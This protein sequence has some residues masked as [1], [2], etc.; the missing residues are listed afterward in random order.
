MNII[1]E[2]SW[3]IYAVA[4]VAGLAAV[5][6]MYRRRQRTMDNSGSNS[7]LLSMVLNNMTQGVIL[8]DVHERVLSL[9]HI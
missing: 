5:M 1:F 6:F 3:Q 9:I 8:F 4:I 7:A 2:H